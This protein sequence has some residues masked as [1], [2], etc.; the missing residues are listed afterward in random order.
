[1]TVPRRVL[2]VTAALAV[3]GA[4][5]AVTAEAAGARSQPG[6]A[7]AATTR[8]HSA[9][10]TVSSRSTKI[11]TVIVNGA[12]HTL[13]L[14]GKDSTNKSHCTGLCAASWPPLMTSGPPK[15]SGKAKQSLL[16]RIKRGS[17]FQV[18]YNGHPVYTYAGDSKAGQTKG[19]GLEA[20][21][22]EWYAMAPGGGDIT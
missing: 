2:V 1:M 12:Q 10:T 17:S 20:Y 16:G 3:A 5:G 11:G 8:P 14:F 13:Y 18:T 21:G 7:P 4:T 9:G 19:E 22:G 6:R 15:A